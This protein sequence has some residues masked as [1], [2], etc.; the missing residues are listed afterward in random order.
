MQAHI[1]HSGATESYVTRT[2]A[3][4]GN[5]ILDY[6]NLILIFPL[7]FCS[8]IVVDSCTADK[9]QKKKTAPRATVLPSNSSVN[10]RNTAQ[11]QWFLRINTKI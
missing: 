3:N 10:F 4:N 8:A 9:L 11:D 6:I 1:Y 2:I 7:N 5:I